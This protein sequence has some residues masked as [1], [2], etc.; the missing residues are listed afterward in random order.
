MVDEIPQARDEIAINCHIASR[1]SGAHV[2]A[3]SDL[4]IR[5]GSMPTI[6]VQASRFRPDGDKVDP[7]SIKIGGV[8]VGAATGYRIT[9]NSFLA[10][11]GDNFA[12]LVDGTERLGGEVDLDALV[13][14]FGD[15]TPPGV[16]PGPQDRIT[17]LN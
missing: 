13:T 1:E 4:T 17:R 11:G 16:D 6:V 9:V 14:F 10:D 2:H 3:A 5:R 8:V 12:T 15:N 7:A